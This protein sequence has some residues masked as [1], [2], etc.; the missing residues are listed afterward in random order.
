MMKKEESKMNEIL[1]R[2]NRQRTRA[3]V[4]GSKDNY[5]GKH[6]FEL[7][8]KIPSKDVPRGSLSSVY[9]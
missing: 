8:L 2:K 3:V 1:S 4:L 6:E 9:P 7:V 5:A